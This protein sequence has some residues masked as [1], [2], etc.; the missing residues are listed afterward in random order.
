MK[1]EA[2]TEN[3]LSVQEEVEHGVYRSKLPS[4]CRTFDVLVATVSW[5]FYFSLGHFF[6]EKYVP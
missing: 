5:K 4:K 6:T 1:S 3:F 2:F